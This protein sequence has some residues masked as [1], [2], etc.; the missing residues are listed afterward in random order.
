MV[1]FGKKGYGST[2]YFLSKQDCI[3][4]R[5]DKMEIIDFADESNTDIHFSFEIVQSQKKVHTLRF[6]ED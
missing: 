1:G 4:S 5:C 6:I 2:D 3:K